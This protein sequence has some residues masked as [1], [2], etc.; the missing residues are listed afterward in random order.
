SQDISPRV[1]EADNM[2]V[3]GKTSAR[4]DGWRH[5]KLREHWKRV[6]ASGSAVCARCGRPIVPGT[7]WDLGHV[8]GSEKTLYQGPEH[9]A[10]N[11]GVRPAKRRQSF[12][13]DGEPVQEQ[14]ASWL[15]PD[16]RPWSR[17]WGG[18]TPTSPE[19]ER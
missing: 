7:P 9:R 16:G 12:P 10:C 4:G 15:S 17:D 19:V 1:G 8:D 6:V 3:N 5:Q 18:G 2:P 11:R 14:R 13:W